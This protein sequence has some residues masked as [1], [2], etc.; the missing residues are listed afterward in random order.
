M[1]KKSLV[2]ASL[3]RKVLRGFKRIG[4]YILEKTANFIIFLSKYVRTEF[5]LRNH[6]NRRYDEY[7]LRRNYY[8]L[9]SKVYN[10]RL[11]H[12][13][14]GSRG[15]S[16][17]VVQKYSDFFETIMC[18]PEK[19]E[20]E[21]LRKQ[22]FKVIDKPLFRESTEVP[23]YETRMPDA[24]S[25]YKPHGPYMDF[26]NPDPTYLF[27]YDTVKET[28]MTCSTISQELSKLKVLELDFLKID[29]QGSELDILMG[30]GD[31]QPLI[32]ITEIQ[33]LP[34]YDD[35]PNAY[36]VCQY[37][38]DSGYIPFS[39][40]SHHARVLCPTWGDGFFMPSWADPRGIDLIRSR[41]E[42]YIALMLMFGQV[43][44][45][46]FVNNKIELKN[47]KFIESLKVN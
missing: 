9:I 3:S 6:I 27:L 47:K 8:K 43:E 24:S 23:F 37:F 34:M 32:I 33:Y 46:K 18:E 31:Y 17:E 25:I 45:L 26:Y 22:G 19:K 35:M 16:L 12:L 15:G 42:Q 39:I 11:M 21:N 5:E 20:A 44:I 4:R 38:F 7:Y 28:T 36:K 2:K 10:G 1:M 13:D 40:T 29:T 14:I 30:L 41:E